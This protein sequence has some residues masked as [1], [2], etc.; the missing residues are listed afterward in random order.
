M[1]TQNRAAMLAKIHIAK[2]DFNLDDDTYRALIARH[3]GG[4]R[5]AAQLN[6]DEL[7]SVLRELVAKGFRPKKTG[8]GKRPNPAQSRQAMMKKIEALL[9]EKARRD[10]GPVN[11]NYAHAIAKRIAKVDNLSF[12]TDDGLRRVVAALAI[13]AE[14]EIKAKNQ[15][16]H[17]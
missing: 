2:K 6:A 3:S 16:G 17:D 10:G 12:C 14:R 8:V 13:S 15:E 1:T 11:W 9:A 7:D 5:S 4:K